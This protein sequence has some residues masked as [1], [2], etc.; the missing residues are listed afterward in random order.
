MVDQC[1]VLC[2]FELGQAH[3][4]GAPVVHCIALRSISIHLSIFRTTKSSGASSF[5]RQYE[6]KK[7]RETGDDHDTH[8]TP[9]VRR[10]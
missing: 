10:P 2:I 5:V 1:L 3:I 9:P 4:R 6:T 7:I 8:A